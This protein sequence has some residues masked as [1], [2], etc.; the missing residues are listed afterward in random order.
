MSSSTYTA[1]KLQIIHTFDN[2]RGVE[3]KS[4]PSIQIR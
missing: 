4:I 1:K 3:V 2:I